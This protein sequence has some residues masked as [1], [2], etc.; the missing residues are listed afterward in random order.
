VD[1]R[2]LCNST[3]FGTEEGVGLLATGGRKTG[4]KYRYQYLSKKKKKK[5]T[6]PEKPGVCFD[7]CHLAAKK[8]KK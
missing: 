3:A 4:N 7:V 6:E 1:C 5:K 2:K 8:T